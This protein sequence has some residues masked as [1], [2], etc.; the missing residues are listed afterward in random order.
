MAN[1]RVKTT[2]EEIDAALEYVRNAPEEIVA[3]KASYNRDLDVIILQLSNGR[4]A[5]FPREDLQGLQKATP[6]Q[7]ANIEIV[8]PGTGLH[9]EDLDADLYVPAL[10]QGIYG[11][12]K[13]MAEMG[14]KGGRVTSARKK[15]AARKNGR[16]GGRPKSIHVEFIRDNSAKITESTGSTV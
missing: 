15:I 10:L 13:W 5:V 16:K 6:K 7:I 8:G 3:T 4:R 2:D 1:H 9:W 11:T 12:E 14:R